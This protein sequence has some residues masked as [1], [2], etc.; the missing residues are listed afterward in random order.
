[1]LNAPYVVQSQVFEKFEIFLL[2]CITC[3]AGPTNALACTKCQSGTFLANS[4][5]CTPCGGGGICVTCSDASTCTACTL[6]YFVDNKS[7]T[8]CGVTGC[9]TCS[10]AVKND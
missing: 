7:C 9:S 8:S 3:Q 5:T 6:G 2:D 1:M 10:A 4:T